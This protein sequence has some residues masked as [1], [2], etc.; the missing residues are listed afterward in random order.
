MNYQIIKDE[1]LLKDFIKWL[2]ELNKNETYYVCLFTRSKYCRDENG[3]NLFPHIRT[4][5]AQLKRFTSNK[6]MLFQ[7]IKQL[8][9]EFG[10]YKYRNIDVPQ[11]SLALYITVNPRSLEIA[12]KNSIIKLA[13]L[14]TKA[15]DGY[16][17]HQEVMSEIQRAKNRTCYVDFDLDDVNADVNLLHKLIKEH[18][19]LSVNYKILQTKGGFH[20]LINPE[21]VEKQF[22][23]SWYNSIKKLPKIDQVG[24]MMIPLA[25]TSHGGFIPKFV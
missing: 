3:N 23:K 12:A 16:N 18:C 4:D 6:E 20:I 21:S 22:E 19:G 11:E 9:C 17:P 7:K 10:S 14:V 24:D 13:Q 15:Y 25:G 2:P 1:N 8:E 5:K